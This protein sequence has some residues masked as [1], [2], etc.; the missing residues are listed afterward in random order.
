[1]SEKLKSCPFCGGHTFLLGNEEISRYFVLCEDCHADGNECNTPEEAINNAW[2]DDYVN[3]Q[4][5]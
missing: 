5:D 4:E 1:M 2:D 3:F